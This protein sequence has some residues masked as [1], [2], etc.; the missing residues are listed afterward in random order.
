MWNKSEWKRDD[1]YVRNL[2]FHAWDTQQ[3]VPYLNL[4]DSDI[5]E[6]FEASFF[7]QTLY[8]TGP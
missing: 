8:F 5:L 7:F 3:P 4:H 6:D 2:V 1:W